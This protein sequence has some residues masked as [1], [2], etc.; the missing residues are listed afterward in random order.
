MAPE[1]YRA[2]G[3]GPPCVSCC[4]RVHDLWSGLDEL[5]A[6]DKHVVAVESEDDCRR[7][8]RKISTGTKKFSA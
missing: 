6:R 4:N 7:S 8:G 5:I 1:R 3:G 2:R